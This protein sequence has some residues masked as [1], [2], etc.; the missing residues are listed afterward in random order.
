LALLGSAAVGGGELVID[1]LPP[2]DLRRRIQHTT[3]M[4]PDRLS[5]RMALSIS[6]GSGVTLGR[7]FV[8]RGLQ[9]APPANDPAQRPEIKKWLSTPA[10]RS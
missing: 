9:R 1:V 2:N 6:K 5:T 7:M 10:C 4:P 3:G 8:G